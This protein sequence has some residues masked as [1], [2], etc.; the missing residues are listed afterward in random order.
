MHLL[1]ATPGAISDGSE[2]VDPGQTP[3]D[4]VFLSS[5]DTEL[6]ALSQARL[7]LAGA[8][9]GGQ[10]PG[11]PG[12]FLDQR[13]RA[14]ELR[15]AQLG[16]LAHPFSVDRYLEA[17]ACKSR[18]VIARILGGAAYWTYGLE[19]FSIRLREAGVT[20]VALPGNDKPDGELF[21]YSTCS[22][23]DWEALF[24]YAVEGGPENAA[25]FL[26][27]AAHMLGQAK[28][29]P[30]AR[31][32]LRAGVYWPGAGLADLDH[33]RSTWVEGAPVAAL[34]FYRALVQGAGLQPVDM[35][36][37]ALVRRGMNVLPV[38]VASLK[39]PVS[40]A[41]LAQLFVDAPPD[42]VLNA[43]SFAVGTPDA[44]GAGT[45]LDAPGRPVLQVVFSGSSE[46]AWAESARGLTARDIAMNVALPEV[47]GRIL[48]RAVSFKGEAYRDEATECSI[49]AYRARGDRIGFVAALA[50]NW[51]ALA[52]TPVAGK[53]VALILANYPNKDGRLANGVG[54]DTPASTVGVL[55]SLAAAGYGVSGA[56][57]DAAELMDAVRAGPTNWLADRAERQGGVRLSLAGYK[58]WY[59]GLPYEAR[60]QI[61]DR[62]GAP[63]DDP[64]VADDGFALSVLE[65]GNV[66]VGLQP[67][68]GYNIDPEE[69]YHSP[70]LPPPHNYL[71]FYAWLRLEFGARPS[72]AAFDAGRDLWAAAGSGSFG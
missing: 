72:D 48:T 24:S 13:W 25:H 69:T 39:D 53:K 22:R 32:L 10:P 59:A 18:L 23:A 34:V 56:P 45:P 29:P 35:L 54:L 21:G 49:A 17:T 36:V 11:P 46:E 1:A 28:A 2:P 43:T 66:C 27:Y 44:P 70:D 50:A 26:T 20:F 68:R 65:Y 15:L 9:P 55:R 4:I 42:V 71:A 33:V 61:E 31:P 41:V 12:V 67:A 60:V 62:W 40:A 47:D 52:R 37:Q 8:A 3:G 57:C 16:W 30:A 5:A 64:F 58:A 14:L 6:A 38:F 7:H 51:V 63:E 19:Q